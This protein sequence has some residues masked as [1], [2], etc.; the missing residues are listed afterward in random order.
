MAHSIPTHRAQGFHGASSGKAQNPSPI[1]SFT[2][3]LQMAF[4]HNSLRLGARLCPRLCHGLRAEA[5]DVC[6]HSL[7]LAAAFHF[8]T[9][10]R[11]NALQS[12][13][14]SFAAHTGLALQQLGL[15]LQSQHFGM[16]LR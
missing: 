1:P 14:G 6:C 2:L 10:I 9:Q 11:T 16:L 5:F 3:A 13:H 4:Q 15:L 8:L 7:G 12:L